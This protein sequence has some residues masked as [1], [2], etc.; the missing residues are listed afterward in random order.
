MNRRLR[1][2]RDRVVNAIVML[3]RGEFLSM[4]KAAWKEVFHRYE[5]VRSWWYRRRQLDYSKIPGSAYV[6][7]RRVPPPGYRPTRSIELPPEEFRVDLEA[8][9]GELRGILEET[10]VRDQHRT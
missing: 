9:A 5:S 7:R 4:V 8:V 10:A 3:R 1:Y 2:L 6:D